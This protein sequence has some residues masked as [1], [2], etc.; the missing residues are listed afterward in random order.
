MMRS[1][2]SDTLAGTP[3]K[4]KD[5]KPLRV[6]FSDTV[7][8]VRLPSSILFA[9]QA[10]KF[11][12]LTT[13]RSASKWICPHGPVGSQHPCCSQ[14][15]YRR[16]ALYCPATKYSRGS[17]VRAGVSDTPWPQVFRPASFSC[18]GAVSGQLFKHRDQ[19]MLQEEKGILGTTG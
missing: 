15:L 19:H 10:K 6:S 12:K 9:E 17:R 18:T 14:M 16:K 1:A 7:G 3:P 4:E 2:N 5:I 13:L 11:L 8:N